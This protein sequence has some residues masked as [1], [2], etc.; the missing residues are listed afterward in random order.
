MM[1]PMCGKPI[2]S[3]VLPAAGSIVAAVGAFVAMPLTLM[4]L[5]IAAT[6]SIGAHTVNKEY[7]QCRDL[8]P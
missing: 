3:M 7:C 5:A 6:I 2:E 1:C 8:I 4:A